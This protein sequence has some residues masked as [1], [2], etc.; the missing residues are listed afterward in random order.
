MICIVHSMN[1]S[2]THR[3]VKLCISKMKPQALSENMVAFSLIGIVS[4]FYANGYR[5]TGVYR[6]DR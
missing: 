3:L 1:R 4:Y 6:K 2:L 5:G